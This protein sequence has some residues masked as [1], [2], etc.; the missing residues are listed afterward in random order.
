[1]PK[2]WINKAKV[3]FVLFLFTTLIT[4]TDFL[5]TLC[6]GNVL[7]EM[8]WNTWLYFI[9]AIVGQAAMIALPLY[10]VFLLL[11]AIFRNHK[12]V[13]VAYVVLAILLQIVVVL[14]GLVFNLYRFHINGFVLD[15][16][17]G[18]GS[19]VFV[20]DFWLCVKFAGLVLL[21]AIIP[22][23]FAIWISS[24]VWPNLKR[25]AILSLSILLLLCL[26]IA[27]L[28]HAYASA[29][30]KADIRRSGTVMPL[31]F[32]LRANT[33]FGKLG[34][35]VTDEIDNVNYNI[36]SA[37]LDY[38]KHPLVIAD[39]IPR[40][41]VMHI[42]IDSW[43]PSVFDSIHTPNI[44][45]FSKQAEFYSNH[46]S[47][48]DATSGSIFGMFFG[49][50]NTYDDDF[51]MSY[52]SPLF[53][54]QLVNNNYN[55][56]VFPSSTFLN[57]PFNTRIFR[58]AP[59]INVKTEGSSSFERDN[60]LTEMALDFLNQQSVDKPYYSLLFYDLP[61]AIS[62][63]KEYNKK[64]QPAWNEAD[65]LSLSNG[66]DREGFFNLYKNCVYHVDSL[67]GSVLDKMESKGMLENTIVLITGDHGQ[68]F[69]ENKKNYWGHGSNYSKWQLQIPL[70]LYYPGAEAGREYKHMTT[71]YD[72]TPTLMT[73]FFGVTNPASDYSFGYDLT[74][75]RNRYPHV[76]GNSIRFGFVFED[77]IVSTD[78][79]GAITITDKEL[80]DLPRNA[81][82]ASRL[83]KAIDRKNTFYK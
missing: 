68:E 76:V 45:K 58:R 43:N 74:D 3:G 80:N 62:I 48:N 41:N 34:M 59:H 77:L 21:V 25:K 13:T 36:A 81:L 30:R 42:L 12:G 72:I 57:P 11:S 49:I 33:L 56:Q 19:E 52:Q 69:N 6:R 35:L 63:P 20:F 66:T 26:V 70:I 8:K 16:F 83:Q 7:S 53:I 54:D 60:K 47:S 39:S 73:R 29:T 31:F 32:P 1:M 51:E 28:G 18:A 5:V 64:F 44:Y 78:Y 15:L 40:Y 50:P 10:L 23:I 55:I 4:A 17:F 75:T 24:R 38:P 65:Y 2:T 82:N 22:Y 79:V 61:H 14:D 37:D 71:H 27:H 67:V 46:F 9:P